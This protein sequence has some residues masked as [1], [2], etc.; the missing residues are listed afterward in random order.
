[1][2][3]N[4]TRPN[5]DDIFAGKM[6]KYALAIAVAKRAREITDEIQKDKTKGPCDKPVI[7]AVEEFKEHKFA[8]LEPDVDD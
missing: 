7:V 5:V 1:M 2:Y 8:I 3:E 4:Y 6:S